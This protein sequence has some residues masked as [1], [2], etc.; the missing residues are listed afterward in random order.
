MPY[1]KSGP[2]P[3]FGLPP[4]FA[5]LTAVF[6]VYPIYEIYNDNANGNNVSK[7]TIGYMAIFL[8]AR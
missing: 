8:I 4:P 3:P 7:I 5:L 1:T 6:A 2:V